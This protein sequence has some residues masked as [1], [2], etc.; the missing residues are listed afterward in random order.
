MMLPTNGEEK[1]LTSFNPIANK[2]LYNTLVMC[3]YFMDT[4]SL[5][6]HW[7]KKIEI[8]IA[9]HNID[10]SEMGFPVDWKK[11]AIWM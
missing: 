5:N 3:A 4:I 7:K 9:D 10:V 11:R 6:H 1:L 8:L 2:Q